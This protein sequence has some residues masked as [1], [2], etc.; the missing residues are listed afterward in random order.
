MFVARQLRLRPT[1]QRDIAMERRPPGVEW[2]AVPRLIF[3]RHRT[4]NR[5]ASGMESARGAGLRFRAYFVS[6]RA[7]TLLF[8]GL[9]TLPRPS[10]MMAFIESQMYD[11]QY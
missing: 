3:V 10:N 8:N 9:T 6:V 4:M 7:T 5:Q 1:I 2:S 11:P